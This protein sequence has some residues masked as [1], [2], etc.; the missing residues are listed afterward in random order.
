MIAIL[1]GAIA[2]RRDLPECETLAD[3]WVAKGD[4]PIVICC[5][6][7]GCQIE[8]L[9]VEPN[10]ELQETIDQDIG[11][12]QRTAD[13]QHP[14]HQSCFPF[15]GDADKNVMVEAEALSQRYGH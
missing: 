14:K 4:K 12:L 15:R 13:S 9:L 7:E 11:W 8:Y 2:Y 5:S 3:G 10:D 6:R 1:I